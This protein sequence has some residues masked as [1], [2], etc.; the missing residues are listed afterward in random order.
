MTKTFAG[1]TVL[2]LAFILLAVGFAKAQT[3][4]EGGGALLAK[5][6][7]KDHRVQAVTFS[8]DGKLLAAGYGFY[9]DGGVT[10]WDVAGRSVVATLLSRT[11]RTEG[12][13]QV[14]F[15]DDGKLFAAASDK[16][17][18]MLWM[19]GSW[20]THKTLLVNRGVASGLSFSPDSTKLAYSSDKTA[21]LYDLRSGNVT[22]IATKSGSGRDFNGISFSPDSK[23]VIVCGDNSIQVWDVAGQKI[24]KVWNPMSPGFFGLLSPDGKHLIAGGGAIYGEKSVQVWD[25][26]EGR[27]VHELTDFRNGL[28]ALAITHSGK[29][30]AVAGG[31][32]GGEGG[33]SLWSLDEARELGFVSFGK[34]PIQGVAFSPD[35][36]LLAAASEDGFVLIYSVDRIRGPQVKKQDSALCGEIVIEGEQAFVVPLSKVPSPMRS[37]FEFPWR[38]E[39]ANA[40]SVTGVAGTPVVLQ[41]WSIESSAA[42][43]RA[44]VATVRS[45]L[46]LDRPAE[47]NSNH[48]IFGDVKNPG[49]NESFVVKIYGNGSFVATNNSGKCLAYGHLDQLQT[50]FESLKKRLVGAG[51]LSIPKEPLTIGADHYRTRFIDLT[52]NGVPE[53]RSDAESI[54]ELLKGGLPKKREAFS[55]IFDK[56]E[57]FLTSLLRAGMKQPAN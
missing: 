45:L 28:F 49:W 35:D 22:V 26:P 40:D 16:G 44:R 23:L 2:A 52:L 46:P 25:F 54:E 17:K 51:L 20:R 39:V 47:T 9:D 7:S 53:L 34:F 6:K 37:D 21:L 55:R 24:I 13:K 29:L 4:V 41:D 8:P 14:A 48:I 31:D 56:E 36:S 1:K 32:Y 3:A 12:I 57:P 27:K 42:T 11:S 10:I 33:L 30:F 43:D 5:L 19:V 15:S 50:D 38:L 18:V